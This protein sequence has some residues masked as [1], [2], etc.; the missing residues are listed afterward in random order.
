[1]SNFHILADEIKAGD[2]LDLGEALEVSPKQ[3]LPKFLTDNLTGDE[4]VEV[5]FVA[6]DED[7]DKIIVGLNHY[8]IPF[9]MI[10][11]FDDDLYI[12]DNNEDDE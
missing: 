11:K 5:S 10:F 3:K 7:S 6:T 1:M 12:L 2:M 8:G 4:H 9:K